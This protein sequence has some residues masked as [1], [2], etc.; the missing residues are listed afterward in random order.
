M[1]VPRINQALSTFSHAWNM[2]PLS[3]ESNYSPM[4]LFLRHSIG[5][6]LFSDNTSN[7]LP[8]SLLLDT[9]VTGD[10]DI[11]SVYVPESHIPLSENSLQTL[12]S[13]IDPLRDSDSYG[14]DIYMETVPLVYQLMSDE[15]LL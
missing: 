15:G 9:G 2:H 1:Y 7:H 12:N 4:Q 13:S 5:N 3:T 11:A 10:S 6:P 8:G 14:A